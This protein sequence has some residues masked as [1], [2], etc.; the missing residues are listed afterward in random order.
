MGAE[1]AGRAL[2]DGP[3]GGW[4]GTG[5]NA[6]RR[7]W[8]C[9]LRVVGSLLREG[10]GRA[11]QRHRGV[12]SGISSESCPWGLEGVGERGE[13]VSRGQVARPA[14]RAQGWDWWGPGWDGAEVSGPFFCCLL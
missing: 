10:G 11:G 6:Q 12:K 8:S 5:K 13:A 1:R 7:C 3:G 4:G 14:G 2:G 9:L